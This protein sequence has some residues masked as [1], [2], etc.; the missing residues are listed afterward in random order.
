M[1]SVKASRSCSRQSVGD[2]LELV[3]RVKTLPVGLWGELTT[4]ARVRGVTA[5]RSSS[6]SI[7]QSGSWS[8]T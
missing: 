4:I 1:S 2:Q 8:V 3:A 7:D 5:A 6:G